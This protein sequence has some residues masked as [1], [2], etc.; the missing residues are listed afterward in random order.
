MAKRKPKTSAEPAAKS[1]RKWPRVVVI[2]LASLMLLASIGIFAGRRSFRLKTHVTT[3]PMAML[4][5]ELQVAIQ[6]ATDGK[7]PGDL[8]MVIELSVQLTAQHLKFGRGHQTCL[9]FDAKQREGNSL[10]FAVLFASIFNQLAR[11]A[12]LEAMASI[13]HSTESKVFGR[14]IGKWG[15]DWVVVEPRTKTAGERRFVDPTLGSLHLGWNLAGN[16]EG[17]VPKAN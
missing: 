1:P 8:D 15:H 16:V 7:T 5:H 10:E 14:Q 17:E 6:K 9:A 4:N 3:G 13:V 12:K 11:W 2:V